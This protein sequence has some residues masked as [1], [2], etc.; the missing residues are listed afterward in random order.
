MG[1]VASRLFDMRKISKQIESS[2][3]DLLYT[4]RE[5]WEFY[6]ENDLN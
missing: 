4:E 6:R 1:Y 2:K 5:F 3:P